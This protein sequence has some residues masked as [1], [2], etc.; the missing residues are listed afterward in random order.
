MIENSFY[1]NAAAPKLRVSVSLRKR[2]WSRKH[3]RGIV[4]AVEFHPT[5]KLLAVTYWGRSA[6]LIYRFNWRGV[7]RLAQ[8]IDQPS[9]RLYCP[10]SAAFSPDGMRLVVN[11]YEGNAINVYAIDLKRSVVVPEPIATFQ[12]RA[13]WIFRRISHAG[14]SAL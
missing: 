11:N 9:A 6:L 3:T 1:G 2:R 10:H 7:L 13:C 4:P 5:K 8:V 12:P 14:W